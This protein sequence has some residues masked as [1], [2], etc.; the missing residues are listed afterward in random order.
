MIEEVASKFPKLKTVVFDT[1]LASVLFPTPK[2]LNDYYN[3]FI[4]EFY[5]AKALAKG[6]GIHLES[7]AVELLSMARERT[8]EG[9]MV[10]TPMG[11]ISSCSRA[12]TS[13]GTG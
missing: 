10:L 8:C 13:P 4:E 6:K 7:N 9:K 2:D 12:P 11:T 3:T 5:K 1:V